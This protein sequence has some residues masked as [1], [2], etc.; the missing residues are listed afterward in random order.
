MKENE[1]QK[2]CKKRV[3]AKL[4]S[5]EKFL[6]IIQQDKDIANFVRRIC[7]E[8][9]EI[10]NILLNQ[11]LEQ[12]NIKSNNMNKKLYSFRLSEETE[13]LLLELEKKDNIKDRTHAIEMA[14]FQFSNTRNAYFITLSEA[15]ELAASLPGETIDKNDFI[16]IFDKTAIGI[17]SNL[18][19]FLPIGSILFKKDVHGKLILDSIKTV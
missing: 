2:L 15:Y 11:R 1:I 14:I 8:E 18:L 19:F 7:L 4:K 9:T 10:E 3:L 16:A 12:L 5:N 17:K 6:N 13:K